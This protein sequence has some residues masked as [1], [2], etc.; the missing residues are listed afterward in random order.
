MRTRSSPLFTVVFLVLALSNPAS[1]LSFNAYDSGN[2]SELLA[3]LP[4]DD[5]RRVM[6]SV[7]VGAINPQDMM[8]VTGEGELTNDTGSDFIVVAPTIP[9]N[10]TGCNNGR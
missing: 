4:G 9:C 3:S 7:D 10:F 8:I 5:V 6:Y 1:A 2:N